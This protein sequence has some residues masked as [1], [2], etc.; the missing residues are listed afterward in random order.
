VKYWV[1]VASEDHVK[2]AVAGGFVQLGHGKMAPVRRLQPGDLI[3]F[4]SPRAQMQAGLLVRK[5]TAIGRVAR[6]EPYLYAQSSTFE[7]MRRDV[8]WFMAQAT[9]V[10]PLLGKLSFIPSREHW[11]LAFRRGL[12]EVTEQDMRIMA[13]AMKA[14]AAAFF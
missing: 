6:R 4:Y 14:L 2:A 5:F 3:A 12:I 9:P 1:G 10:E 8:A 11:G 7:P 13:N